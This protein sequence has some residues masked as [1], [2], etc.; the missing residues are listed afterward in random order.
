MFGLDL[1]QSIDR[2]GDEVP[3]GVTLIPADVTSGE[4]AEA[5]LGAFNVMGLAADAIAKTDTVD[6]SG[7]RVVINTASVAAFEGQPH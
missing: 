5:A 3:D 1:A 2:A 6:E 7:Q 4:D